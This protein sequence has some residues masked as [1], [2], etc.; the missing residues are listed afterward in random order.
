M[1]A[2]ATAI[3]LMALAV[4][5]LADSDPCMGKGTQADMNVCYDNQF[6]QADKA[7]NSAYGAL[8]SKLKSDAQAV[9]LLRTTQRAWLGFRD[10]ECKLESYGSSGGSIQPTVESMCLTTVTRERTR[11]LQKQVSCSMEN[12]LSCPIPLSP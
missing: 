11:V 12:D 9:A 1:K 10:S 6:K 3:F 7:L 5:A 2:M 8:V 4:P